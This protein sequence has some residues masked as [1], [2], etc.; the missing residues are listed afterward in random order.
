MRPD[1][2]KPLRLAG[3]YLLFSSAWIFFSDGLLANLN[4]DSGH[5]NLLQ[6]Y[7]GLAFVLLS[8]L[9]I[10]ILSYRDQLH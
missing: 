1:L 5:L 2:F 8:T 3:F 9:L 7:K 6:T 4:L 10:F